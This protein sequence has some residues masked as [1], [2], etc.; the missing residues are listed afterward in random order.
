MLRVLHLIPSA[1][2]GGAERVLLD[3]VERLDP[4]SFRSSV[5]LPAD[6]PLVKA[7]SGGTS[8]R[9]RVIPELGGISRLGR[10]SRFTDYVEALPGLVRFCR[11][12]AMTAAYA[13]EEETQ[14]IHAHGWKAQLVALLMRPSVDVPQIWHVHDFPSRR[15]FGRLYGLVAGQTADLFVAISEAVARDLPA[16]LPVEVVHNGIAPRPEENGKAGRFTGRPSIAMIGALAP[17]K[18]HDVFIRAIAVLAPEF[19]TLRAEIVGDEIYETG[20]HR[21]F[22]GSLEALRGDLGLTERVVFRGWLDDIRPVLDRALILAHASTEPEP[23]GRVLIEAMAA[24]LPVVASSGGGV[25]EVVVDGKTGLIVKPGDHLELAQALSRLLRD[26]ELRRAMGEAGRARVGKV[27]SIHQ[28]VRTI[29][30]LY[31]RVAR[32]MPPDARP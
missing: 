10:Y 28:Q 29:A 21:G 4:G 1:Q 25:A 19:P 15:A 12:A 30:G 23:F 31:R 6:G 14:L 3:L 24:G 32:D 7:L 8:A 22:R 2:L 20:G 5:V 17:W 11:G 9:V 18:G 26:P 13:R 27:F 16:G